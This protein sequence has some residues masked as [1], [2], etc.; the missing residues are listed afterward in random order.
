MARDTEA[1]TL[2]PSGRPRAA[3]RARFQSPVRRILTLTGLARPQLAARLT[4]F[5]LILVVAAASAVVFVNA[6]GWLDRP[7]AGF[8]VNPRMVVA[9]VGQY[10]WTGPDAGVQNPDRIVSANGRPSRSASTKCLRW[11]T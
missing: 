3:G 8:L 4:F 1:V 9:T 6:L 5:G 11:P 10:H 2:A 7:F